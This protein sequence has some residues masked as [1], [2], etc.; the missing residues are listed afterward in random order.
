MTVFAVNHCGI[1]ESEVKRSTGSGCDEGLEKCS[2]CWRGGIWRFS[3]H[4]R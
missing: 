3:M 4:M 1:S 2:V